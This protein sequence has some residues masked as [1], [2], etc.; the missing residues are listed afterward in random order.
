MTNLQTHYSIDDN[1]ASILL[2]EDDE[3][4]AQVLK[5]VL[6]R[7][8]YAVTIATDGRIAKALIESTATPPDLILLDVMLPYVDGFELIRIVRDQ[9]NWASTPIVMLSAKATEQDIVRALDSGANDYML[10]PF[11][12]E[13]LLARVRRFIREPA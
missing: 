11:Q 12:M 9:E 5:F 1:I 2:I 6:E 10:K 8:E 7:H 13:E 4:I 3:H